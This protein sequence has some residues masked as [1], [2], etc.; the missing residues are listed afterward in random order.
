MLFLSSHAKYVLKKKVRGGW[1]SSFRREY[2]EETIAGKIKKSDIKYADKGGDIFPHSSI[3][4]E[5]IKEIET[6]LN[7]IAGG[8]TCVIVVSMDVIEKRVCNEKSNH[9]E[10]NILISSYVDIYS[11]ENI[12]KRIFE[13]N[14]SRSTQDHSMALLLILDAIKDLK[15]CIAVDC[16]SE[17]MTNRK[18]I[19][20]GC[21]P[22]VLSSAVGGILVHEAIGH[23]LELGGGSVFEKMRGCKIAPDFV[24]VI[25]D[26][27]LPEKFGSCAVDDYGDPAEKVTLIENGLLVNFLTDRKTS[28]YFGVKNNGH[29][30]RESYAYDPSPRMTNTYMKGGC[31]GGEICEHANRLVISKIDWGRVKPKTGSFILKVSEAYENYTST[32]NSL[33]PF[34]VRGNVTKFLLDIEGIGKDVVFQDSYCNAKS[35]VIP[36]S[37]GQPDIFFRDIE[38]IPIVE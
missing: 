21:H 35:G 6:E 16:E 8:Y 26:P 20:K 32:Q 18:H 25:D 17:L 27:S 33:L 22:A 5:A 34:Y 2:G 10:R 1:Y 11:K 12:S 19:I 15:K 13:R 9:T 14:Y 29:G 28:K 24:T 38:C 7:F 31:G 36:V 37:Y 4:K 23:M 30:R 3:V